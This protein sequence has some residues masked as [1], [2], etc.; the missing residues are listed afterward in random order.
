[1]NVCICAYIFI[2]VYIFVCV[3]IC[4][5]VC[6]YVCVYIYI[7]I[8]IYTLVALRR[9]KWK[10]RSR[11]ATSPL[12]RGGK[13]NFWAIYLWVHRY[14]CMY[15]SGGR[16][17]IKIVSSLH[18]RFGARQRNSLH[19]YLYV[20]VCIYIYTHTLVVTVLC[21]I[22]S[23]RW[24]FIPHKYLCDYFKSRPRFCGNKNN[25]TTTRDSV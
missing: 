5:C 12:A 15:T 13:I 6:I 2:C 11:S 8:Y 21:E 18:K 7:Y 10:D 19:D 9:N 23:I 20:Y 25:T 22:L 14:V 17:H 16:S 1:M 4:I 3:Y 24:Y